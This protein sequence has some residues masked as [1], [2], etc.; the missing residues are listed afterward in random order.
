MNKKRKVKLFVILGIL[1]VLFLNLALISGYILINSYGNMHL[2]PGEE[3]T[4]NIPFK[5][6]KSAIV[7][8]TALANDGTPLSGIKV[9]VNNSD[10]SII[11]EDTTD[12][13]GK[14]EIT[15]PKTSEEEQVYVYLEYNNESPSLS[16]LALA[17]ND[18]TPDFKNNLNYSRSSDNHVYLNGK[19]TNKDAEVKDGRFE[20]T[21]SSCEGETASCD[22]VLANEK[23]S[24]NI[25][26]DEVYIT[27]N[28][29]MD[30]SWPI[31]SDTEIGKYKIYTKASFNG[32]EHTS[33]VYFHITP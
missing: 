28:S 24:V 11:G 19:I 18:Y 2:K 25:K 14:Y 6:F 33:T 12:S 13:N 5:L 10:N 23:Y 1:G 3:Y 4:V 9:I 17:S 30:F 20:I 15:L 26:P 32:Q 29:E 8:G 31:A 7:H 16:N 21:L 27:P 22:E